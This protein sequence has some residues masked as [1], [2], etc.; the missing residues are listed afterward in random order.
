MRQPES[1]PVLIE[2]SSA[3]ETT[4]PATLYRGDSLGYVACQRIEKW[5]NEN[6]GGDNSPAISSPVILGSTAAIAAPVQAGL[7]GQAA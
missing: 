3:T 5:W 1:F 6:G 4:G 2:E 7:F